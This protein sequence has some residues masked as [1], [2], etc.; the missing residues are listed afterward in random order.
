MNQ[1]QTIQTGRTKEAKAHSTWKYLIYAQRETISLDEFR[2][3]VNQHQ[4]GDYTSRELRTVF[5]ELRSSTLA[6]PIL[7][8]AESLT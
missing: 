8:N 4:G 7:D 6:V 3:A 1:D 2:S 5:D